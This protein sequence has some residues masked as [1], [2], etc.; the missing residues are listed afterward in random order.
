MYLAP[1]TWPH[2]KTFTKSE[3]AVQASMTSVGVRAP[4]MMSLD[5][6][7]ANSTVARLKPGVT[8]NWAPASMQRRAAYTVSTGPAPNNNSPPHL[9]ATTAR[10]FVA[11]GT[12]HVLFY[13]VV[14]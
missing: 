3:P 4:A 13:I 5:S 14:P 11:P 8:R 10:D 6:R 2:G 9:F 12:R 1:S 7:A